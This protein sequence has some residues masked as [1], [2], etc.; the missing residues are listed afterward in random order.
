MCTLDT[1]LCAVG[2]M[3]YTHM[4]FGIRLIA[5]NASGPTE[6][7]EKGKL[8]FCRATA[9]LPPPKN[10]QKKAG[11]LRSNFYFSFGKFHNWVQFHLQI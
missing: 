8:W 6:L 10:K 4:A 7:I 3:P 11:R 5:Q 9:A 1:C 2:W